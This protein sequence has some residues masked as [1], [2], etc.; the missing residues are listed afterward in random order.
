MKVQK[1]TEWKK[2][3]RKAHGL[4]CLYLVDNILINASGEKNYKGYMTKVRS[5]IP[6]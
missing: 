5:P 4:I 3:D 6:K 1:V 2:L